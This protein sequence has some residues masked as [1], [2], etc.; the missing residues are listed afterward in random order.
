[1]PV[2]CQRRDELVAEVQSNLLRLAELARMEVTALESRH[3]N[4]WM[5]LDRQIERT[6]GEKERS[7]GALKEH[8]SEHGC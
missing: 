4:V 6:L 5:D 1:M 3:E 8:R 7:L 2:N